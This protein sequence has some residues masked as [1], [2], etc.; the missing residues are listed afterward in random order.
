MVQETK[1]EQQRERRRW[2]PGQCH[3]LKARKKGGRWGGKGE[4][5]WCSGPTA[6]CWDCDYDGVP[7]RNFADVTKTMI[8]GP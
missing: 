3:D 7:P 6:Q 2:R 5:R 1:Q 4:T 8:G